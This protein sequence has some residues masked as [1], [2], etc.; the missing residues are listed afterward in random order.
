MSGRCSAHDQFR[1][2]VQAGS[3]RNRQ[4]DGMQGDERNIGCRLGRNIL[5]QLKMNRSGPLFL[6]DAESIPDQRWNGLCADDLPRHLGQWA[7]R[8]DNVDDLKTCLL[9]S[10]DRLLPGDHDHGHGAEIGISRTRRQ[11]ERART[12]CAQADA[13][14]AG[15]SA[16]G[17]R[18]E[19]CR[20]LV[21][22]QHERDARLPQRVKDVEIFFARHAEDT[23][24][25][26]IFKRGNEQLSC[27]SHGL[28]L[29]LAVAAISSCIGLAA[30][31]AA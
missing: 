5:R 27:C 14:L 21:P 9:R 23:G 25:A 10:Q 3:G 13:R 19:G 30:R 1:G 6:R 15:Q 29:G 20:L 17:R 4:V 26:F 16:F 11:I 24:D 18:H 7:H 2:A 31:L 12:E 22:R 28:A 8:V